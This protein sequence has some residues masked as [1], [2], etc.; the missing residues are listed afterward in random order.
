MFL[1]KI[2]K[3]DKNDSTK[4]GQE[5]SKFFDALG[6]QQLPKPF[7]IDNSPVPHKSASPN[8]EGNKLS[9]SL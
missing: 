4:N 5:R 3:G 1:G 8:F 7:T 9:K 6:K 2:R